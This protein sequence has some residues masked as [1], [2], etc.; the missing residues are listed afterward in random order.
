[1]WVYWYLKLDQKEHLV[2]LKDNGNQ[3]FINMNKNMYKRCSIHFHFDFIVK[4]VLLI[5]TC[6]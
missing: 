5:S 3:I 6:M 2:N 4:C 1:M